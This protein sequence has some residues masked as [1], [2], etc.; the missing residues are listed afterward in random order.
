ML[1][2]Y[3]EYIINSLNSGFDSR[4]LL[5]AYEIH[6]V[7]VPKYHPQ[8]HFI[9]KKKYYPQKTSAWRELYTQ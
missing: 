1:I 4:T 3:M 2:K 9:R 7:R 8:I 5:N 6:G